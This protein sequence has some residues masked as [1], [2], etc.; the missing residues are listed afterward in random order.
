M[1]FLHPPRSDAGLTM[2]VPPHAIKPEPVPRWTSPRIE[3]LAADPSVA[4]VSVFWEEIAE[5]GTPLI[6]EVGDATCTYTFVVR[7]LPGSERVALLGNKTVDA[8][9]LHQMLFERVDGT[10]VWWLSIR[11]GTGWR[12]GYAIAVQR[13]DRPAIPTATAQM[14]EQRRARSL[15]VTDPREHGLIND[16]YD[17][18]YFAAADPFNFEPSRIGGRLPSVAAGPAA[19]RAEM[20]EPS[21]L[22]GR[23]V[24]VA[25]ATGSRQLWWHIPAGPPPASWDVLVMLDGDRWL[26]SCDV[27]DSW[28]AS[29]ILPSTV[30]LL[31]G[32]DELRGRLRDLSCS[33]ELVSELRT[34]LDAAAGGSEAARL[35]APVTSDPAR[36]RIAGQSLGG[37]TALYAQC[38]A[39]ERFG[40]SISQSGSFWWPNAGS[41]DGAEWLTSAIRD[42]GVHLKSVIIEVGL[43]EWILL[44][45]TRR[46]RDV[47]AARCERF[48]YEEFD[49]GHDEAC[50]MISL[51]RHLR[52]SV[53]GSS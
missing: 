47:L 33:P 15:S 1:T 38:A 51:P 20:L 10:D 53:G 52:D 37:L 8:H 39:P 6:E 12:G 22:E 11:L 14:L 43:H 29:G 49:G 32:S 45:P 25:T 9:T 40:V 28:Q 17:L 5:R 42:S 44:E 24:P 35:G 36:T 50:W 7:D 26:N 21:T 19:P 3:A 4:S 23:I 30:T 48:S 31:V 27:L 46:I 2:S 18:H 34:V 16:W 13:G 41:A